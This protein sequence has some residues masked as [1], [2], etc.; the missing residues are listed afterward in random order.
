VEAHA[1]LGFT[2]KISERSD[3]HFAYEHAFGNSLT[4][5]GRGDLFSIAGK[6]TEI[7]LEEDT[8]TVQ[9]SLSF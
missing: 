3:L 5:S 8:F 6:G 2:Y 4:D 1:M 9:Y 7:Y